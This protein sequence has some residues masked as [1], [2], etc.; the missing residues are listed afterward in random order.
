MKQIRDITTTKQAQLDYLENPRYY[1]RISETVD[2]FIKEKAYEDAAPGI[3]VFPN[4]FVRNI[5][6]TLDEIRDQQVR[7]DL[8]NEIGQTLASQSVDSGDRQTLDL[9]FEGVEAINTGI[10]FLKVTTDARVIVF[11]MV[12]V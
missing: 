8:V 3:R 9:Q 12:K 11:K 7:I 1:E 4:P 10:Y 6:L 5:T 2:I